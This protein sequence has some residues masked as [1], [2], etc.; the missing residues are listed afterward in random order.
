MRSDRALHRVRIGPFA[1]VEEYDLNL[2]QVR[3]LGI[4]DARLLTD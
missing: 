1:T 4:N 3:A 2:A